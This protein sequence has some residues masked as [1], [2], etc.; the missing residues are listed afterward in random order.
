MSKVT[1]VEVDYIKI[2]NKGYLSF[3]PVTNEI[4]I[5]HINSL[6]NFV[7]SIKGVTT[8]PATFEV[9]QMNTTY[10]IQCEMDFLPS[11]GCAINIYGPSILSLTGLSVANNIISFNIQ[12]GS[13][14]DLNRLLFTLYSNDNSNSGYTT[15]N[16]RVHD[17]VKPYGLYAANFVYSTKWL[18]ITPISLGTTSAFSIGF[19]LKCTQP[20]SFTDQS[21]LNSNSASNNGSIVCFNGELKVWGC[22]NSSAKLD[23]AG[24]NN[25]QWHHIGIIKNGT[26]TKYYIDFVQST[27][28]TGTD[29]VSFAV[30][31]IQIARFFGFYGF[32]GLISNLQIFNYALGTGDMQRYAYRHIDNS[33][34]ENCLA[35]FTMNNTFN[36]SVNGYTTTNSNGSTFVLI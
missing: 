4:T 29:P 22:T 15:L 12:T 34:G 18:D 1:G 16:V 3:D 13:I 9:F 20:T 24:V 23:I 27:G 35:S 5:S 32:T 31:Y 33:Q 8:T 10:N 26:S 19:W 30:N 21:F 6:K 7:G 17:K 25:Q 11:S 14:Q 36:S 2:N 28:V